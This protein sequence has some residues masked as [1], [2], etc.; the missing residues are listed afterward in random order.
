[1]MVSWLEPFTVFDWN[2]DR[3]VQRDFS[4]LRDLFNNRQK[5]LIE[6]DLL[7]NWKLVSAQERGTEREMRIILA[8]IDDLHRRCQITNSGLVFC[9]VGYGRLGDDDEMLLTERE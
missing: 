2:K 4:R 5:Y 3:K 9:Y 7:R 6:Q 1:M 8:R